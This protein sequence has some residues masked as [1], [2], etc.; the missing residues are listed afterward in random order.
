L[1]VVP[2]PVRGEQVPLMIKTKRFEMVGVY[3]KYPYVDIWTINSYK[4]RFYNHRVNP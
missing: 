3:S 2:L 1:T 4:I